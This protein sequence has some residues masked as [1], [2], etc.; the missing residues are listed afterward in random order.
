M[1][2]STVPTESMSVVLYA[3]VS[4][5]RQAAKDLSIPDQLERMRAYCRARGYKVLGEYVDEGRSAMDDNRPAFREM[6]QAIM[7]GDGE[8]G[9]V[10][11]HSFSRAF[12]NATDLAIYLRKLHKVGARLVSIT[13]DVDESPIGRF[14]TLFYGLVDEMNSA[15][16][17][18]HVQRARQENARRGNFNGSKPPYGYQ[19]K[20][21]KVIGHTGYRKILIEEPSE[22]TVVR[23]IFDLYEGI[24]SI[25]MGM[26]KIVE[27]L[28]S[29]CLYRGHFWRVQTVQKI[30][31]DPVYTGVYEFGARWARHNKVTTPEHS[32]GTVL[33]DN[34]K[35]SFIAVPVPV[36]I[37]RERFSRVAARRVSRSPRKTPPLHVT[38]RT[39]LTGLCRCGYCDSAMHIATGKGGR[40]RYLKCNRR[41]S[42]SSS[43]CSSPNIPYERFEKLILRS[44]IE[45]TLTEGRLQQ[46][47]DDCRA[48]ASRL[49]TIQGSEHQKLTKTAAE[50][51]RK[52]NNLYKLVEDDKVFI[53]SSL[54]K[55]MQ[56]W[57]D[58]L[59]ELTAQ[60]NSTKVPA[61]LPANIINSIDITAFRTAVLTIL[62]NPDGDEAKAFL[63]L[64]VQ[65]IRIYADEANL[66]GPN[67]G[68][69]EA[70]L[71]MK[72]GT[73]PAVPSFMCNWRREGD[74][75]PR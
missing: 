31:S 75:N 12:R 61:V 63:H 40:Y 72:K 17:S 8:I 10:I 67:V 4:T 6:I 45:H 22:A 58:A 11:V 35:P 19:T 37:D 3:R 47:F 48:H 71:T 49:R 50:V 54:R 26:K 38:P 53:D 21:T 27:Y 73:A 16:N 25:P 7:E 9:A 29:R 55:R 43:I 59:K 56:T 46:I 23:E 74:S 60:L 30:L 62:D 15:E 18:K 70:A 33:D 34:K 20:D 42:I 66:V 57:Q 41:G 65:E 2:D 69:V 5:E 28:N 13:Q 52:L 32:H 36:I 51:T 24:K 68:M 1:S 14:V 39:L 44:V 64:A